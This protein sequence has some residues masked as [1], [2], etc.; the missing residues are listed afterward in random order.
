MR[1]AERLWRPRTDS[2]GTPCQREGSNCR[3]A[4]FAASLLILLAGNHVTADAAEIRVAPADA[5]TSAPAD[6]TDFDALFSDDWD[7]DRV[8]KS[9]SVF[10]FYPLVSRNTLGIWL[11][12]S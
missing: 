6:V 9:I 4:V 8:R 3:R 5:A 12:A 2:G 11:G 10:K 1:P 7:H